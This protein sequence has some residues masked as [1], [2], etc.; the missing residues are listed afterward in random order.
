MLYILGRHMVFSLKPTGWGDLDEGPG[1]LDGDFIGPS[2]K[3]RP[4]NLY[5]NYSIL[6]L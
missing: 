5:L 6:L 4:Y 2:V 3:G 1:H